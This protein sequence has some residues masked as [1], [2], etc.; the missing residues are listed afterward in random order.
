MLFDMVMGWPIKWMLRMNGIRRAL[1]RDNGQRHGVLFEGMASEAC[2]G[3]LERNCRYL[4][5]ITSHKHGELNKNRDTA[6]ADK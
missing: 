4:I 6:T 3:K 2:E 5:C 1:P